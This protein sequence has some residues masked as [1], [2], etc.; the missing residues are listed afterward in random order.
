[1]IEK[2]MMALAAALAAALT[3]VAAAVYRTWNETHMT[4]LVSV[5]ALSC[6]VVPAIL[7]W[8]VAH[9][10]LDERKAAVKTK[11][12]QADNIDRQN[13]LSELKVLSSLGAA[14]L[15]NQRSMSEEARTSKL[16]ATGSKPVI[17]NQPIRNDWLLGDDESF[18]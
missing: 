8:I 1:M 16:L 15:Q 6:L 10:V 3:I 13:L 18:E 7:T 14:A 12:L 17:D 2:L 5:G 4:I 11:Q 9:H